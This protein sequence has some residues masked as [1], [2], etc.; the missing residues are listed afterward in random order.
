MQITLLFI[1]I[2]ELKNYGDKSAQSAV[3]RWD[4]F[5]GLA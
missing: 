1:F 2:E 3:V 4:I 5:A